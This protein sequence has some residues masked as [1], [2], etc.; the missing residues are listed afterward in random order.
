MWCN[1]QF[2]SNLEQSLTPLPPSPGNHWSLYCLHSFTFPRTSY[3]QN[4]AVCSLYRLASFHIVKCALEVPPVFSWLDIFFLNT[5]KY[6]INKFTTFRLFIY[7]LKDI[8]VT[9]KFWQLWIKLLQTIVSIILCGNMS[10]NFLV[11]FECNCG[12]M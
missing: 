7:L 5:E 12:I 3:G 8:L 11:N 9:S 4:H 6:S 2:S 1:S 10:S